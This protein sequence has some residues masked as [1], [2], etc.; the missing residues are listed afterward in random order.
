MGTRFVGHLSPSQFCCKTK[1]FLKKLNLIFK[2]IRE[3]T[4]RWQERREFQGCQVL[5]KGGTG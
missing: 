1:S 2:K 4:S 5:R 3:G